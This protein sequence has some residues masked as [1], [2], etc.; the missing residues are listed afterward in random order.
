[1]KWID[2]EAAWKRQPVAKAG[3][4]EVEALERSFESK[5]RQMSQARFV[6]AVIEG[7]M[8][9]LVCLAIGV[10][11]WIR[12]RGGWPTLFAVALILIGSGAAWFLCRRARRPGP[13]ADAPLLAKVRADIDELQR[14]RGRLLTLRSSAYGPVIAVVLLIPFILYI[15]SDR[16]ADSFA[17]AFSLYY[18]VTL[19][20]GWLL[21]RREV[22]AR[23]DPRLDELEKLRQALATA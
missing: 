5:R 10:A 1:M 4:A 23:I 6:R 11:W 8:A 16:R 18:S 17:V 19:V 2:C 13:S 3:A 15:A 12:G 7:S 9:P 21:N 14:E 22:R 20:A